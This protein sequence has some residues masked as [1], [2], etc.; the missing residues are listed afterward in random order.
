LSDRPTD[1][2]LALDA[3]DEAFKTALGGMYRGLQTYGPGVGVGPKNFDEAKKLA[4]GIYADAKAKRA[5]AIAI[6]DEEDR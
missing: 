2:Q 5:A 4:R 3:I 1:R 6:V